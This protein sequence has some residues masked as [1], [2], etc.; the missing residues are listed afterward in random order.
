MDEVDVTRSQV[1]RQELQDL[2]RRVPSLVN[3]RHLDI[4][5][6]QFVR[7]PFVVEQDR[8]HVEAGLPT[9]I[10]GRRRHLDF[11][12]GPQIGRHDVTDVQYRRR[13]W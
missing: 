12:A 2:H 7:Q 13:A 4:E 10:F 11:G 1:C 6:S 9:E 8:P 3:D 5:P